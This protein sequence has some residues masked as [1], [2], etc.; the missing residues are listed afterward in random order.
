MDIPDTTMWLAVIAAGGFSA[1]RNPTAAALVLAWMANTA[2]SVRTDD[3]LPLWFYPYSDIAAIAIIT[4]NGDCLDDL[5]LADRTVL[6]FY[7]V[8]W[9]FYV[10]GIHDY[11]L[12]WAL[13]AITL[14]QFLAVGWEAIPSIRRTRAVSDTPDNP[15]GDQFQF[16]WAVRGYG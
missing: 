12:Y 9:L 4:C 15:P 11:Y 3:P 7:P 10:S 6:I 16:A 1:F 14:T 13:W 8:C 5:T 2:V